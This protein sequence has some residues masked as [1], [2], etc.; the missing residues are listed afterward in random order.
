M[1]G[2]REPAANDAREKKNTAKK[3]RRSHRVAS[4]Q[5]AITDNQNV[6]ARLPVGIM[7]NHILPLLSINDLASLFTTRRDLREKVEQ[8][9]SSQ[10]PGGYCRSPSTRIL[11]EERGETKI[12]MIRSILVAVFQVKPFKFRVR[13]GAHGTVQVHMDLFNCLEMLVEGVDMPHM[14]SPENTRLNV[15]ILQDGGS[16]RLLES[17]SAWSP[18]GQC[19]CEQENAKAALDS[20][21]ISGSFSSAMNGATRIARMRPPPCGD[22]GF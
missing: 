12:A 14:D 1:N 20:S 22:R 6:F 2:D 11:H 18:R 8:L 3:P 15:T 16:L 5:L 19:G 4:Q 10:H 9:A 7:E 21:F 13:T 17:N